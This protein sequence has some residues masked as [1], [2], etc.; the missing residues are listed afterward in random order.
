MAN[1]DHNGVAIVSAI[2]GRIKR[3]VRLYPV[4]AFFAIAFIYSWGV[5]I[6]LY[7]VVGGEQLGASR[8]WQ[9]PFAWGPPIAA[10]LVVRLRHR[11]IWTWLGAVADPRTNLRWYLLAAVV[12]FLFADAGNILAGVTGVPLVMDPFNE[13]AVNFF[14]T[15]FLAGSLEEFGWRG[16]AQ[17]Y[18]Q[19]RYDALIAAFVIGVGVGIWHYPWLL[20]AGAGYEEAGLGDL[21]GLPVLMILMAVIFAWLFNGSGGAVPVVMFG[22]AIFNATPVFEVV[23]GASDGLTVLGLLLWL[24]LGISLV[25]VYGRESLAPTSPN[26]K[27]LGW[28]ESDTSK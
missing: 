20:L 12:S 13:I 26:F 11:D 7:G 1:S 4:V 21:I 2:A 6:L 8:L 25:I 16:F 17:P 28:T 9:I 15:L 14:I 22:H 19:E 3:L 27:G 5:F 18:L 24:G 10:L 23:G